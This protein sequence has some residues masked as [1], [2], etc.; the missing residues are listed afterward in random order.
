[1]R[2]TIIDNT[3]FLWRGMLTAAAVCVLAAGACADGCFVWNGGVDLAEPS[4]KAVIHLDRGTETLVLQV[5]YEG[6]AEDFAW[7]VPLPARPKVA[8]IEPEKSPF[9]EIS[10]FTQRRQRYQIEGSRGKGADAVTVLERKVVGGGC[11]GT[12]LPCPAS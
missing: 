6:R 10:R 5:K 11:A 9:A 3:R 8:A 12:A 1:M 7:I 2:E 4:Q